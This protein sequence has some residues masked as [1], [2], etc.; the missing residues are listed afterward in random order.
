MTFSRF[1]AATRAVADNELVARSLGHSPDVLA[2]LN[3]SLGGALAGLAGVML[4]PAGLS[5][6][7][8]LLITVPAFAAAVLG[9]FR[10]YLVTTAGAIAIAMAQSIFTFQAVRE[11]WPASIAPATPFSSSACLMVRALPTTRAKLWPLPGSRQRHPVH[12]GGGRS[13]LRCFWR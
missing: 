10:S 13:W 4:V 6:A 12:G 3:W 9:G 7:A 11:G 5:I 1:G 2:A 8:V